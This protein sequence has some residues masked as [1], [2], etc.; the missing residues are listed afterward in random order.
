MDIRRIPDYEW[1]EIIQSM[2]IDFEIKNT[3]D[4]KHD[5]LNAMQE[6]IGKIN[7]T[8]YPD[9]LADDDK[10]A[11]KHDLYNL[12]AMLVLYNNTMLKFR[13][14]YEWFDFERITTASAFDC[15]P[16]FHNYN[17][18]LSGVYFSPELFEKYYKLQI[19]SVQ[20]FINTD[21]KAPKYLYNLIN[22]DNSDWLKVEKF[23]YL[24]NKDVGLINDHLALPN[25]YCVNG[26]I[27]T[28][29][30]YK[31]LFERYL[32]HC[33]ERIDPAFDRFVIKDYP[34]FEWVRDNRPYD[35]NDD[36]LISKRDC[37]VSA[38][39]KDWSPIK[40]DENGKIV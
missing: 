25:Y 20:D 6:L 14:K 12:G 28:I 23:E 8:R 26:R 29:D 40:H 24:T 36:V 33:P 13:R 27:G 11:L 22:I 2:K 34:I 38:K 18:Y 1:N 9:T 10:N 32:Q 21:G 15:I 4:P 16:T 39:T 37:I 3:G 7:D 35:K 5:Y 19:S 30:E 17:K 31:K